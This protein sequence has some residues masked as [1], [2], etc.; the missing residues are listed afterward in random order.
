[1][2][3]LDTSVQVTIRYPDCISF[4]HEENA[5]V[6]MQMKTRTTWSMHEKEFLLIRNDYFEREM[7]GVVPKQIGYL[8][9]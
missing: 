7:Q 3:I 2:S 5:A 9:C 8:F 6:A 4:F 1:M